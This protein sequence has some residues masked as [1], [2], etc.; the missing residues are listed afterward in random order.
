MLAHLAGVAVVLA[1]VVASG[2]DVWVYLARRGV[3]RLVDLAAAIVRRAP[4]RRRW[5]AVGRRA[6]RSGAVVALP[7]QQPPPVAPRAARCAVVPAARRARDARRR[8]GRRR[9]CRPVHQLPRCRPSVRRATVRPAGAPGVG[10]DRR[11]NSASAMAESPD[12]TERMDHLTTVELDAALD[13]IRESPSETG[14]VD[15]IVRRPA[16]GCAGGPRRGRARPRLWC[17]RRHVEHPRQQAHRGRIVAS[18]HAAQRD[19]L[20]GRRSRRPGSRPVGAR[21]R[22][23]VRRPRPVGGQPPGRHPAG[24]RHGDDRGHRPTAHRLRQVHRTVRARRVPMGQQRRRQQASPAAAS[25]PKSSC[26]ASCVAATR[27]T[28]VAA[29]DATPSPCSRPR[30]SS[31]RASETARV[32]GAARSARAAGSCR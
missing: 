28:K 23:A 5:H 31:V 18:R 21:R 30:Q 9:R 22:S 10:G 26:L 14:T 25:T 3:A 17:G 12:K 4:L 7:Q 2:L 6:R 15:L 19:E 11:R 27:V 13:H 1:V 24:A 16:V 8:R 29:P 32:V 20:A